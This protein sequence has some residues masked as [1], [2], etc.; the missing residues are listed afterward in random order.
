MYNAIE[1][2]D[3]QT[4]E[5]LLQDGAD[6]NSYDGNSS[7]LYMACHFEH[8][9]ACEVLLKYGADPNMCYGGTSCIYVAC[10]RNNVDLCELLYNAGASLDQDSALYVATDD[11]LKRLLQLGASPNCGLYQTPLI[12]YVWSNNISMCR[13]LLRHGANP[14]TL[15]NIG[16]TPIDHALGRFHYEVGILLIQHGAV[17]MP[18]RTSR[19]YPN[20]VKGLERYAS[21]TLHKHV[22]RDLACLP[23]ILTLPV[24]V[25]HYIWT[26]VYDIDTIKTMEQI[27]H[28]RSKPPK[29][30]DTQNLST[31]E[32]PYALQRFKINT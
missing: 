21:K 32:L 9:E 19:V 24:M 3:V 17:L 22:L 5:E 7:A 15:T 23:Y 13:F 10:E 30:F 28:A 8:V 25:R 31:W 26:W 4:L 18:S 6:P 11:C 20:R 16:D 27:V 14:H 2:N 1:C 29:H 12:R